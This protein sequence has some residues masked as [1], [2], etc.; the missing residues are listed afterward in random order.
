MDNE[1]R[2]MEGEVREI[3][4]AEAIRKKLREFMV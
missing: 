1:Y 4:I 3:R 2:L